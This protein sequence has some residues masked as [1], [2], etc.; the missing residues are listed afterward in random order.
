MIGD[1]EGM[2]NLCLPYSTIQ[3]IIE[4]LLPT[5]PSTNTKSEKTTELANQIKSKTKIKKSVSYKLSSENITINDLQIIKD[6]CKLDVN[7][8]LQGE[9]LYEISK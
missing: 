6:A 1:V 4:K 2:T 8:N 3:P 9:Y 7:S 5:D